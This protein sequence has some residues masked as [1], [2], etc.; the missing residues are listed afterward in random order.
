M[1]T[2]LKPTPNISTP[3]TRLTIWNKS[4]LLI[5]EGHRTLQLSLTFCNCRLC[6]ATTSCVF[7]TATCVL[8]PPLV[9]CNRPFLGLRGGAERDGGHG[10]E[11][12]GAA[13]IRALPGAED[14]SSGGPG[15][16]DE[17][18]LRRGGGGRRD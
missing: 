3:L 9:F 5:V 18:S 7:V 2:T 6:A 11:V 8:K 15:S 17:A 16:T 14:R 4:L 1:K 13:G 10:D 12:Q